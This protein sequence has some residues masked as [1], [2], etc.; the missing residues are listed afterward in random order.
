MEKSEKQRPNDRPNPRSIAGLLSTLTFSWTFDTFRRGYR[1]DLELSDLY[2]PLEEH[3]SSLLGGHIEKKWNQER[4]LSWKQNRKPSLIKVMFR[5]YGGNIMLYGMVLALMEIVLRVSQPLFLGGLIEY[6]KPGSEVTKSEAYMYALGIVLCSGVNILVIHPYMMGVMHI[7]M[8]MRLSC[9]SL[10]YRKALKLSKTA[11][12]EATV[13]QVVN[14]LSNDVSRFD[15]SV[16]FMHYLWIGPLQ[17]FAVTYFL[18]RQIGIASV[19]GVACLLVFIPLQAWLGKKTST[20]RLKTAIRIDKRVR[21]MNEIITGIQVI[22]M[23]TWE[24][25]FAGIIAAARRKEIN[26]IR[27]SAY[28]RGLLTSFNIF[29]IRI[30]I[31]ASVLAYVWCGNFINA[32]KVFIVT[33]YYNVLQHT[34]TVFM[35]KAITQGAEALVSF[36]RLQKFLLYDETPMRVPVHNY[37]SAKNGNCEHSP[38]LEQDE[39][40]VR[41]T[42]PVGVIMSHATA[43]WTEDLNENTLNNISLTV[44]PGQLVA[45]IGPVAAGKSSLLHAILGELPITKG[46]ISVSGR[47]SYASQEPWLFAGSVRQNILFGSPY[48]KKRYRQVVEVCALW[49]DFKQLH[50]GDKTVVG[51][52]GISLSGGQKARINLARAVYKQADIYLLDDPLSA[53]DTYVSKHLFQQCITGFLKG[54]AV[55]LVTHQLQHLEK[56]DNMVLMQNGSIVAAG[57][58]KDLQ[59]TGRDFTRLLLSSVVETSVP[60]EQM[61]SRVR[62]I[63]QHSV[64]S[65][66]DGNDVE[67]NS[68]ISD[69][70][71]T[72]GKVGADVFIGYF[73][74]AGRRC[75]IALMLFMCVLTQLLANGGDYWVTHWVNL[76]EYVYPLLNETQSTAALVDNVTTR[77]NATHLPFYTSRQMCIYIFT[78]LIFLTFVITLTRSY[79]L[80][81]IC[82]RASKRLHDTMFNSVTRATMDFFHTNTSGRILNR[83]SKDISSVDENLPTCLIECLQRGLTM[84]G[85]IL[86]VSLVNTS[87]IGPTCVIFVLFY[88]LRLFYVATSRSV[89]RLEAM[90]RS[91]VFSHLNASLQGLTTIR[92]F[93]AQDILIS[94]FDGHQDAHSSTWYMFLAM[95]RAFGFWLDLVCLAYIA[96][97]V[98][99]FLFLDLHVFGGNVGLSITQAIGLTGMLQFGMKQSAELENIMTCVE[100][101]LEYSRLESEPPLESPPGKSPPAPWPKDGKIEFCNVSLSYAPH[102]PRVLKNV[103]FKVQPREKVGIVGRT[104]SGKTSLIMALFRLHEFEGDILIDDIA[105]RNVGLHQFRSKISIIPQEPVLFSGTIR[106]NL[107][108]FDEFTDDVLWNALEEVEMKD[109][110]KDLT[111]GLSWKLAEGGSNFSVGQRQLICLARAI[112]RNNRILVLDEATANVDPQTD[113]LIQTTIRRKFADC[114]VLTIAHRLHT[115]MDSDKLLVMDAGV[116]VEFDHPHV[117]LGNKHGFFYRMVKESGR[118][119][120]DSLHRIASGTYKNTRRRSNPSPSATVQSA[121]S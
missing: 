32:Q 71:R 41:D 48:D 14:L 15:S 90:A 40:A 59:N 13:G 64:A 81:F 106:K 85:V 86:V 92:A 24:K 61:T 113:A 16:L 102:M 67:G 115:V 116:L 53:V 34:M 111:G 45:V 93:Q 73:T 57:S 98:L 91:P 99:S 22:K 44:K 12:G 35:P 104:G 121:L 56:V 118:I 18:W 4:M 62:L 88:Y 30:A 33:S 117:L 21:L 120:A 50:S 103:S 52:R 54:K 60:D 37:H 46:D 80:F 112:I 89:K 43:K 100:R 5:T 19:V 114:T 20:I 74:A 87:I 27:K 55:I 95:S 51:D 68:T 84:V 97:V 101:V 75:L 3:K 38:L 28:V 49:K 1:K 96:M 31:F 26:E 83:F 8:K 63:S 76:E 78:A 94:E 42:R 77:F 17:T 29:H 107:D 47:L 109:V 105:L 25:P 65:S 9:C 110:V 36:M 10:I 79:M 69:E 23:Y 72:V 39:G 119:T 108:P 11:L 2:L 58:Y 82:M 7:G 70:L 6:F 66:I